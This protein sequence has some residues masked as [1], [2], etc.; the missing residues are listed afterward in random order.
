MKKFLAVS[1]IFMAFCCFADTNIRAALNNAGIEYEVMKNGDLVI[2]DSGITVFIDKEAKEYNGLRMRCIYA[3]PAY[4]GKITDDMRIRMFNSIGD[5]KFGC[6]VM[7][8][9][10]YCAYRVQIPA[11]SSHEEFMAGVLFAFEASKNFSREI[12]GR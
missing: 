11:D 6:W 8:T 12:L 1:V 5:L 4:D 7:L 2:R 9:D 10:R 3:V